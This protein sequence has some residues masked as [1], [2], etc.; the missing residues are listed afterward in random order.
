MKNWKVKN[1][2]RISFA[3]LIVLMLIISAISILGLSSLHQENG[4]LVNKTLANTEYVWEMRR[5]LMSE[6][7]YV[8]MAFAEKD[9]QAMQE[10]S[11]A[12]QH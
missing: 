10:Y 3:I 9:K 5:N 8:L 12:A 2:L 1:K 11:Q 4:T 7:R 6:Q